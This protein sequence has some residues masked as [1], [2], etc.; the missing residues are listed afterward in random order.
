VPFVVPQAG[1]TPAVFFTP[2]NFVQTGEPLGMLSDPIDFATGELLS[3]E[4]GFDPTD[5]AVF[6]ALRTVRGSGS[7]VED[8]GQKLQDAKLITPQL[9]TFFREEIRLALE[10]LVT[11]KQIRLESI[12]VQTQD[13]A[14]EITV[15]YWNVARGKSRT[16]SLPLNQLL[17]RPVG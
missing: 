15:T 13:T 9:V 10:H 17:G 1:I 7:A 6:T 8:V 12:D 3:I 16:V 4:R 11:A 5:A 2:V 14:A